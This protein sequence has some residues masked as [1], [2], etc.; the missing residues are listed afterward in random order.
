MYK[1]FILIYFVSNFLCAQKT[2]KT[3]YDQKKTKT[4]EIFQSD[5]KGNKNGSFKYFNEDGTLRNEGVFKSGKKD[6]IFIEYIIFPNY[7]GKLQIKST[8]SYFNNVREG[9]AVYYDYDEDLGLYEVKKGSYK[10]DKEDG[11][12]TKIIPF[13]KIFSQVD[14]DNIKSISAFK[15]SMGA[16]INSNYENGIEL[17]PEEKQEVW[18]YPSNKV[19]HTFNL[20]N[21][22]PT[23]ADVYLFPDGKLWATAIFD[24]SGKNISSESYYYSG[25]LK[26]KEVIEPYFYEGYNEDG[27]PNTVTAVKINEAI[28]RKINAAKLDQAVIE[29]NKMANGLQAMIYLE[30][31]IEQY[32]E[33]KKNTF[34][35]SSVVPE[36]LQAAQNTLE[37]LKRPKKSP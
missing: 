25:K 36:E 29:A 15:N 11:I 37:N 5:K 1:G 19:Y 7:N 14:Y 17:V 22:K 34:N 12:W 2:V 35:F 30:K 9:I 23:G 27:S 6:G 28:A 16:K 18:Y 13:K 4:L 31:A 32:N 26:Q 3:Y 20:H 8:E 33:W 10:N 21:G 24:D